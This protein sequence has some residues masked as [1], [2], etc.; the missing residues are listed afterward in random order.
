[1]RKKIFL[2][3]SLCSLI[4]F[5]LSASNLF[6]LIC[7]NWTDIA[8]NTE[9]EKVLISPDIVTGASLFLDSHASMLLFSNRIELSEKDGIDFTQLNS[10]IDSVIEKMKNFNDI[11]TCLYEKTEDISY[12]ES[13]ISKLNQFDYENF[14]LE[15]SL[16]TVVFERVKKYLQAGDMRGLYYRISNDSIKLIELLNKI[17]CELEEKRLPSLPDIWRTNQ[18]FSEMYLFGQYA[19]EV[20]REI[21][22]S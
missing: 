10:I 7:A 3:I 15:R 6:S 21:T 8:F 4:I 11:Y 1:M 9:N 5:I 14:S 22:G 16:N 20:C 12:N 2:K 18:S 13:I 17:K 19:S